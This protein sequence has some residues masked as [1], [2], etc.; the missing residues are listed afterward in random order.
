MKLVPGS[1]LAGTRVVAGAGPA[2]DTGAAR[3][4]GTRGRVARR[5][6]AT[7]GVPDAAG[8]SRSRGRWL[9]LAAFTVVAAL[10]IAPLDDDYTL[11]NVNQVLVYAIV[12]VGFYVIL[13]LSG[14]FAFSQAALFGLGAYAAAWA[15]RSVGFWLSTLFAIVVVVVLSGLFG[16]LLAR[17]SD[18]YFAIATLGLS[19]IVVIVVREWTAFTGPGGLVPVVNTP[20]LFGWRVESPAEYAWLFLGCLVA[21]IALITL[22]DHSPLRRDTIA[23]RDRPRVVTGL[24]L[25][26]IGNKVVVFM[27]GSGFAAF[28]GSLF[29]HSQGFIAPDSFGMGLGIDLFLLLILGGMFSVWGPVLGAIFVVGVPELARGAVEYRELVFSLV[30]VAAILLIP[31]GF[32]GLGV[33]AREQLTRLLRRGG[34]RAGDR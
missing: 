19:S 6:T 30:L 11:G 26:V 21:S 1:D 32:V 24:G 14:Q 16:V 20:T 9:T 12:G 28:A 29:A 15:G 23:V 34:R 4:A 7:D 18:L 13:G 33:Q 31:Q 3:A 5:S 25:S 2:A 27:V 10:V 17:C 8:R 22:I